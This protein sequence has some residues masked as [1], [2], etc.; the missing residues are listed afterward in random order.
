MSSVTGI[1]DYVIR[2]GVWNVCKHGKSIG[3]K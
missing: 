1:T 3:I 2:D